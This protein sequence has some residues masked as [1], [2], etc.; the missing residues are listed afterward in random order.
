MLSVGSFHIRVLFVM[1]K[2][3]KIILTLLGPNTF[4]CLEVFN[5]FSERLSQYV[6]T[7]TEQVYAVPFST[8]FFVFTNL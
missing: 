6:L 7:T 5:V 1:K 4:E 8:L 3:I 2:T